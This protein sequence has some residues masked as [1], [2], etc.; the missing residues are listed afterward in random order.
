MEGG[1]EE[2]GVEYK[3]VGVETGVVLPEEVLTQ[4]EVVLDDMDDDDGISLVG[5]TS[6]SLSNAGADEGRVTK[7]SVVQL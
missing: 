1:R 7:D 3:F 4:E 6:S 5:K 2:R